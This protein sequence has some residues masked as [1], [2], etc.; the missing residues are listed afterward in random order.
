MSLARRSALPTLILGLLACA[1][2]ALA[3]ARAADLLLQGR[4]DSAFQ[5]ALSITVSGQAHGALGDGRSKVVRW[6][7]SLEAFAEQDRL[8]P[9]VPGGVVFVGSSSI[10]LWDGLE[11]AFPST[12][13]VNR[14]FGGS[15]LADCARHVD[16]LV[17]PH[18]PR[19]VVVYA[20]ENDLATGQSPENVLASYASLVRQ[21][22]EALPQTR[23]AFV[24]VKPSRARAS[25]LPQARQ[26]NELVADYTRTDPRLAY[27]DVHTQMLDAEGRPRA[28]LFKAD[29]LHL[30]AA[31][32]AIWRAAIAP[33]LNEPI[34]VTASA[35]LP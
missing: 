2:F 4:I 14:G 3:S 9:P 31:G 33:H 8:H 17:L 28:E 29:A 32:Y 24:S 1:A 18:K 26:V 30:N 21:V 5:A 7:S 11:Q 34:E 20:G 23:I 13:V 25:Q 10:R 15:E 16:R 19:L 6:R 35:Q 12:S 22:H 27:V